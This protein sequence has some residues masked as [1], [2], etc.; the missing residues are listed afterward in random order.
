MGQVQPEVVWRYAKK[1]QEWLLRQDFRAKQEQVQAV[2]EFIHGYDVFVSFPTGYGKS[3]IHGVLPAVIE[4]A[5]GR[6][7]KTLIAL[8]IIPLSVP[9]T[10]VFYL[11]RMS[12]SQ[13][14]IADEADC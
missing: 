11:H 12:I 2:V 4:L 9:K 8:G 3:P 13:R 1:T 5:R 7:P 10:T 6:P 14:S